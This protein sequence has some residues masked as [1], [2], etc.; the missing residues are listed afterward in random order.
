MVPFV[1]L[2]RIA[3]DHFQGIAAPLVNDVRAD[4]PLFDPQVP[5]A[6][7]VRFVHAGEYGTQSILSRQLDPRPVRKRHVRR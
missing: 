3:G 7:G 4:S 6:I 5:A 1:G 2:E